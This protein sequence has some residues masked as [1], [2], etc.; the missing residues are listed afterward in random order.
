MFNYTQKFNVE[1]HGTYEVN[2]ARIINP[3]TMRLMPIEPGLL[4]QMLVM[5]A[6]QNSTEETS[7]NKNKVGP[8]TY[9]KMLECTRK[10]KKN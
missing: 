4:N 9:I 5:K 6:I 10:V 7:E 2:V 8:G 3:H 1:G